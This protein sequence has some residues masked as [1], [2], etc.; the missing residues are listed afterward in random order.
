MKK[1]RKLLLCFVALLPF[2][3]HVKAEHTHTWSDWE[4]TCPATCNYEGVKVRYC[5]ECYEED[6]EDIPATGKHNWSKWHIEDAGCFTSGSK[7]RYCEYCDKEETIEI[8]AYGSHDWGKWVVEEEP[9][10]GNVGYKIRYCTRCEDD[11]FQE[12]EIPIPANKKHTWSSWTVDEKAD[13]QNS[14]KKSRHCTV[15]WKE[16]T[17]IIPAN[18]NNHNYGKWYTVRKSTAFKKGYS[19]RTCYTCMHEQKKS[20]PLLPEAKIKTAS[21]KQ[22]SKSLNT[23]FTAAKNYDISKMKKCFSNGKI[24]PFSNKSLQASWRKYTKAY[25]RFKIK[26]VSVKGKKATVKLYCQ[27]PDGTDAFQ[28]ALSEANAYYY[29]HPETSNEK[30]NNIF[31][32]Y[33]RKYLKKREIKT[34]TISLN[35]VKKGNTWKISKYTASL[36]NVLQGNYE[37][38][39]N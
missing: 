10:C 6:T 29:Y 20:L 13:C 25:L 9:T 2:S 32:S 17:K 33:I 12:V 24:R 39:V 37:K 11:T 30:M 36:D 7:T 8:P 31:C 15:C 1:S 28:T 16:E 35:M 4:V 21:E 34:T 26:S 18:K 38:A 27:Y 5:T 22:I 23:F 19:I 3:L 14:G